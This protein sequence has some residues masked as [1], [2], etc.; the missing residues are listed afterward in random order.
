MHH[1]H[2]SI[3]IYSREGIDK[4][5]SEDTT[6]KLDFNTIPWVKSGGEKLIIM[7]TCK[8]CAT[9]SVR[10]IS[11]HSYQRGVV[12]VKWACC[13]N[14]HLITSISSC[15]STG[16]RLPPPPQVANQRDSSSHSGHSDSSCC[17]SSS[18]SSKYI[19]EENV[20]EL[21]LQDII[22]GLS[23][24]AS[25]ERINGSWVWLVR[26]HSQFSE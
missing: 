12:V 5:G 19:K 3:V 9:R 21:T 17:S 26:A 4:K 10:K 25:N 13:N 2:C 16:R 1:L 22:E 6:S 15:P 8:V 24:N 20:Y 14:M 23:A 11:K 7:Y 18:S